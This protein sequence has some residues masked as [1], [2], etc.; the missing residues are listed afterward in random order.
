VENQA[1]DGEPLQLLL[2]PVSDASR[3]SQCNSLDS[4]HVRANARLV[5][6][7]ELSSEQI[8]RE[9]GVIAW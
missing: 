3:L 8:A 5:A 1:G 7:D 6:R 9:L 4:V 2:P